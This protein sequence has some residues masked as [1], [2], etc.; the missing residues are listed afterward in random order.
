MLRISVNGIAKTIIT[1]DNEG[2]FAYKNSKLVAGDIV[3]VEM[4]IDGVYTSA[5]EIV[6]TGSVDNEL[7]LQPVSTKDKK[8]SGNYTVTKYVYPY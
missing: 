1:T 3:R 4:K 2:E 6:V 8:N 5:K 7:T